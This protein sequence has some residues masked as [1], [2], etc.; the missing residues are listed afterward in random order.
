MTTLSDNP[1]VKEKI[2]TE[3]F[4]CMLEMSY[5]KITVKKLV[6]RM[7]MSRQNFYRYYISKDDVL[8]DLIDNTLDAAYQIIE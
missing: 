1:E 2:K 4:Q 8:V 6:V 7:G 5:S 3:L